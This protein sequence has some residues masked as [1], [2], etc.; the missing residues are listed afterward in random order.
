MLD[1]IEYGVL[2]MDAQLRVRLDNRAY[3]EIWNIPEYLLTGNPNARELIDY[4]R[5]NGIYDV[6]KDDWETYLDRRVAAIEKGNVPRTEIRRA[7]GRVIQYQCIALPNDGR[8]LTYFDITDL[9]QAEDRLREAKEQAEVANRA[10]SQFLANMSHELRTPLNAILGYAELIL[11]GIYG[12][13]PESIDEVIDRVDHN[14]RHLL[15][16]INDVLDLSK[17]EAGQ[18]SLILDD[19]T[20]AEIVET[21]VYSLESLAKE[22]GLALL[23]EVQPD[24]PPGRGDEQRLTQVLMNLVGNA[25]K[26]TERGKVVVKAGEADGMFRILVTYTGIGISESDR[27]RIFEE[28]HQTDDSDTRMR[29]GSGLGL[30]IAKRMV[31]MHGGDIVAESELGVGSTVSF[32]LPVRLGC[33]EFR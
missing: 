9:K 10:K 16:L 32:T 28:F 21:A 27:Q 17:I 18:F 1:A 22:K 31:E 13:V 33:S 29:G 8:M 24:L 7:D 25:I 12:P 5:D 6:A 20:V 11:D 4:N 30:A 26:F 19:Y 23:A 2:F 15:R 3:R 14:G